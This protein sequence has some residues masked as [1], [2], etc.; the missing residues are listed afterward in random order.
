MIFQMVGPLGVREFLRDSGA[1]TSENLVDVAGVDAEGLR[2]QRACFGPRS[3]PDL[4]DVQLYVCADLDAFRRQKLIR[5]RTIAACRYFGA[6][7]GAK[8]WRADRKRFGID[9]CD[10]YG[11]SEVM[12]PDS[13]RNRAHQRWTDLLGRSFIPKLWTAQRQP[14]AEREEGELVFTSLTKEAMPVIRYRTRDL[15]AAD[16]GQRHRHAA[17]GQ[18]RRPLR[19]HA[20]RARR[21]CLSLASREM[22][23]RCGRP[24]AA[25]RDRIDPAK[26]P[27]RNSY[28]G[29]SP[30]GVA[31]NPQP[32]SAAS[33]RETEDHIGILADI[34]VLPCGSLARI[35]RQRHNTVRDL[36]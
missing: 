14:A 13:R 35:G 27:R 20:H 31:T 25:L 36:R 12:G 8:A 28:R 1:M 9:A 34:R 21:Q 2:F 7:R 4:M 19:R 18:D 11:L 3:A 10:I 26:S 5:A 24:G 22:I 23:L 16:A 17:D 32:A 30:R 6:D 33:R 29:R 15:D